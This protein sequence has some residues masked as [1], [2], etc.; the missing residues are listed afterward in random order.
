MTT[1]ELLARALEIA[2]NAHEGQASKDG[3]PYIL[4]PLRLADRAANDDERMVALLH[5]TVEDSDMT[6]E[7]LRS[8][9][10]P[11]YIVVAIDHLTR[12][13]GED[14]D[15]FIDRVLQDPLASRVKLLDLDDNMN[16]KRIPHPSQIDLDRV[17]RYEV[18]RARL[19]DA[20]LAQVGTR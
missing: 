18:A 12:R 16:L 7:T 20:L 15:A 10:F 13:D 2:K 1:D 8:E 5:D 6:L 19:M 14:Y 3:R 4:H 9:G 11:D 17:A